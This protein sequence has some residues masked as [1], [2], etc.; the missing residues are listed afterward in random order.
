[1]DRFACY[2]PGWEMPKN[3]S[4]ALTDRYGLI[5]DYLAEAF[6]YQLKHSNRYEE[7]SKRVR[8]AAP[9]RG[10]TRRASKRP[11]APF[12]R[13]STR[14]TSPPTRSSRNTSPTQ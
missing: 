14:Q 7:V 8:L 12:S 6:H 9:S 11:F 4:S 13:F 2:L 1:M 5:T 3:S 10:G